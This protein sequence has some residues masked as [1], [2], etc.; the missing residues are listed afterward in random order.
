VR[1]VWVLSGDHP[2]F[3]EIVSLLAG[4]SSLGTAIQA[5]A[6]GLA[7]PFKE[8]TWV[9]F[10]G[11]P[12]ASN[13]QLRFLPFELITALANDRWPDELTIALLPLDTPIFD[14]P[15]TSGMR[16][17]IGTIVQSTFITCFEKGRPALE[18]LVGTDIAM[19]NSEWNLARVVRNAFA[20]GN[21]INFMNANADPVTWRQISYSPND[22]GRQVMH[23]DLGV[24]DIVVLLEELAI[25][26]GHHGSQ[27]FEDH[28]P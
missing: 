4:L 24:A 28:G 16:R 20:H 14:G 23:Q 9:G 21:S 1:R 2:F 26:I 13:Q 11:H 7:D 6:S 12:K 15:E 18:S 5:Q 19:W 25:K 8:T 22:N 27:V 3:D 17:T 10:G